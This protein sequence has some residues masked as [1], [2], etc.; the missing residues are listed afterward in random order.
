VYPALAVL[1]AIQDKAEV[2]WI[3]GE[4]GME[5]RLVER[6]GIP[7]QTIPAAGVHGIGLRSLPRNLWQVGRGVLASRRI[8]RAFK[9]DVLFFTGGYVAIPM[10]LAG[11]KLPSL[12]YVPDIEPGLALKTLARFAD[13]ICVTAQ[14]S[15]AYFERPARIHLPAQ[16]LHPTQ[17]GVPQVLVTGYPTRS[18]LAAWTR[19]AARQTLGLNDEHPVLLVA[20]GS[21][22]ARSIN[23]AILANLPALLEIAQVVHLSGELDWPVVEAKRNELSAELAAR[24]HA[25]PYLDEQMGAA[26]AAADL[27][28]SRA[29][30]STLG[31]YPL[32]G[33]PAILVPYPHAWRYQRV[34]AEYLVR[35]SAAMLLEDASLSDQLLPAVSA[36][37]SQPERLAA[38]RLA[39]QKLTQPEAAAQIGQQLLALGRGEEM[40]P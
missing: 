10:A 31:E 7:Y 9:P 15:I 40:R 34:N 18:G 14:D 36:L 2:L 26:L 12:L 25:F 32:F 37:L 1:Q 35:Q 30:A 8:L 5:T 24:Y 11:W 6:N 33:L 27:A 39:M 21:K 29:G 20:G 3:G 19:S 16:A 4:G 22:G 28:I 38:M 13:R 17:D 23:T